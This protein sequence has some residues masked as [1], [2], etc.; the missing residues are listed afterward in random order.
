M[1]IITRSRIIEAAAKYPNS[2]SAL[3]EWYQIINR[4]EF[5]SFADLRSTFRSVDKVKHVYVFNIG[6]NNLRLIAA[7]HFDRQKI[8]IRDI[9][10]HADYDKAAWKKREGIQ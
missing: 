6:G 8:Y 7:I 2:A 4:S 1:H 3:R 5:K 10:T 9:L